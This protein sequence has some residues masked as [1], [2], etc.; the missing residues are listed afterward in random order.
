MSRIFWD[1]MLFIYLIEGHPEFSEQ[2]NYLLQRSLERED[3]LFT[4][5][6]TMGEV[7]AGAAKSAF[8]EKTRKIREMMA[9]AGFQ[10]LPFVERSVI[11]FANLRSVHR[12]KSADAMNLAC[13]AAA[14]IDLYLTGD[15]RLL[16]VNVVGVHFISSFET[17]PL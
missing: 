5:H 12:V 6:L 13:A 11:P 10:F 1:T 17:A 15:E 14:G 4:S 7:L 8:P 9:G 2:V 16:K 3:E